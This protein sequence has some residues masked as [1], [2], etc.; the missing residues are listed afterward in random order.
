MKSVAYDQNTER[1]GDKRETHGNIR[2]KVRGKHGTVV[3]THTQE[4]ERKTSDLPK[5]HHP[6]SEPVRGGGIARREL[7][8]HDSVEGDLTTQGKKNTWRNQRFYQ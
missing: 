3:H 6:P 1:G 7:I 4:K 8:L 5:V 2:E